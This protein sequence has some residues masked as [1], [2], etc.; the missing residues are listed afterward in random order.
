MHEK[1]N[2]DYSRLLFIKS[3]I[4]TFI[5]EQVTY[6]IIDCNDAAANLHR[7]RN[8]DE[9]IGKT[10]LEL[11]YTHTF[12][13][14]IEQAV[15]EGIDRFEWSLECPNG[16]KW[17]GSF[18]LMKFD[19]HNQNFLQ[20]NIWDVTEYKQKENALVLANE[21]LRAT[22]EQL[23]ANEE[24]LRQQF[25]ELENTQKL[26]EEKIKILS[27]YDNLTGIKNRC[28]W[29]ETLLEMEADEEVLPLSILM[30]DIN[31][32][33][34]VNDELGPEAGN[35]LLIITAQLLEEVVGENGIVARIGG[36]EFAV[37]L[38]NQGVEEAQ[39]LIHEIEKKCQLLEGR[40]VN[41]SL[42]V[43]AAT[44]FS[45]DESIFNTL[46][47]SEDKMFNKKLLDTKSYRS[48]L[49][50][51]LMDI[52]GEITFETKEHCQR[53]VEFSIKVAQEMDLK[54]GQIEK[55]EI[56]SIM[57]DIGKLVI[58]EYILGKPGPLNKEEW[59]EMKKHSEIGYRIAKKIPELSHVAEE[60][61][62]HHERWDGTGYP[63]GLEKEE[64]PLE[65]RIL[66]VVDA[67]DAM[68]SDR[69]YRKAMTT[70]LAI[71]ELLD[72]AG[73]QFDPHIVEVFVNDVLGYPENK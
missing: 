39:S 59:I 13:K 7:L 26:K 15:K 51:S 36:D 14:R 66:A 3:I 30:A 60:I 43:G 20:L 17:D 45:S 47:A 50:T 2:L 5:L 58:P 41:L 33:R 64:I 69:V 21:E 46:F 11:D 65:S 63:Q 34:Q 9:I 27:A 22:N 28:F 16:E 4:P 31:G 40:G 61:L 55:L 24:K 48:H 32:L 12:L 68:T 53:L 62:S 71:K 6:K 49:I 35:K 8:R 18:Y 29:E 73:T 37:L 44:R 1:D 10:L 25:D 54:N 72:N 19:H 38:P 57:H 42:S 56:L 52:M 23:L 67:F 70:D